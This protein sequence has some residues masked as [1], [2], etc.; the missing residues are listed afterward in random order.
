MSDVKVTGLGVD[1]SMFTSISHIN[2]L[3]ISNTFLLVLSLYVKIPALSAI[4][5]APAKVSRITTRSAAEIFTGMGGVI[6]LVSL[7]QP[8][9]FPG[10]DLLQAIPR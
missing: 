10:Q 2:W 8:E 5:H 7:P 4:L 9:A 6:T 1:V 3:T